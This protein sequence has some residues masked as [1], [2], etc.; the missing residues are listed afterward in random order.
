MIPCAL[1]MNLIGDIVPPRR[2]GCGMG[3]GPAACFGEHLRVPAG[4]VVKRVSLKAFIPFLLPVWVWSPTTLGTDPGP[5]VTRRC[6]PG[7]NLCVAA[8]GT[9]VR[10]QAA[11][12]IVVDFL[13]TDEGVC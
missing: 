2:P 11:R 6:V 7:W 8:A 12:P 3:R 1:R 13:R 4:A 5:G 10:R 9:K